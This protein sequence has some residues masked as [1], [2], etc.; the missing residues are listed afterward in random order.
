MV[1]YKEE[2][3]MH[4][5]II[6]RYDEVLSEKASKWNLTEFEDRVNKMYAKYSH[7][8]TME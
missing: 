6:R 5:E 4:S 7:I 3:I 2:A 8:M 1:A